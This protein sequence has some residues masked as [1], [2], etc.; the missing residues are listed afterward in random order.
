MLRKISAGPLGDV[1]VRGA[2]VAAKVGCDKRGL[3]ALLGALLAAS[4]AIST[5][6]SLATD[7]AVGRDVADGT[8]GGSVKVPKSG[9]G[10]AA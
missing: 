3:G 5:S 4:T 8:E 2:A 7:H 1:L 9:A 10:A 6:S